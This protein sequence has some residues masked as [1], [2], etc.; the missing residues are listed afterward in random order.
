[1]DYTSDVIWHAKE[2]CEIEESNTRCVGCE[3]G[4]NGGVLAS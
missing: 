3:I 4:S 2:G 1:M